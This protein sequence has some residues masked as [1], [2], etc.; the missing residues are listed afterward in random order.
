MARLVGPLI[1]LS[2]TSLLGCHVTALP[3]DMSPPPP[4]ASTI[5]PETPYPTPSPFFGGTRS[6]ASAGSM[7]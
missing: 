5:A 7:A 1:V 6:P 2:M 4:A 3:G